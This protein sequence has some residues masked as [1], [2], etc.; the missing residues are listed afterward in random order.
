MQNSSEFSCL[1]INVCWQCVHIHPIM[2]QIQCY[3]FI[4]N[5]NDHFLGSVLRFWQSDVVLPRLLPQLLIDSGV[6][7]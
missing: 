7:T 4:P 1:N 3:F 6:L 5:N 2:I